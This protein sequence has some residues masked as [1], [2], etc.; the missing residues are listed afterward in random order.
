MATVH[1]P[2]Y[3]L[4]SRLS[5]LFFIYEP[6][7]WKQYHLLMTSPGGTWLKSE[8]FRLFCPGYAHFTLQI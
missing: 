7:E 5:K 8:P 1:F 2:K 4:L 3:P 6:S